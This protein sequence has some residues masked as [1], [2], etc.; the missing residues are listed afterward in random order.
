MQ[1]LPIFTLC[2]AEERA[3]N[4]ESYWVFSQRHAG[5]LYEA[6]QDLANK[7]TKLE[8]FRSQPV[9]A[10][11]PLSD[12]GLFY[13]NYVK[14]Q[15]NLEG[16]DQ[17]TLM[18]TCIYKFARH[19]WV[20][21][22]GAWDA[23]PPMEKC[24][25]VE[26]K[27]SRVHLAEEFSHIRLF[28][29]MLRTFHLDEVEWVSPGLMMQ[30]V[31]RTFPRLPGFLM[32]TP[33]FVTE[34]M[35]M[36]FYLH[37]D[38]LFDELLAETEPEACA[39]LHELLNEIMVDELAHVGQRRNF[40]GPVGIRIARAMI[41]PLFKAFFADIPESKRLFNIEQ[42]IEEAQKFDYSMVPEDKIRQSWV[43][44]YCIAESG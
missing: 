30:A 10:R 44:S 40:I 36:V 32:D 26:D 24:H 14:W 43:P 18:L 31:Y 3:K 35:G 11:K 17:L 13:R 29:E 5:E 37:L 2:S 41:A 42:M 12:P 28:H 33:A 20:G 16:V 9:R 4:F 6:E 39:R 23:T 19:E 15:D 22:V 38:R 1:T 21:I 8:A 27:I 34:L 25:S 7:R